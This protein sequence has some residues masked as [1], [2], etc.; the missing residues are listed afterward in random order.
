MVLAT[1]KMMDSK[2]HEMLNNTVKE[3]KQI[4]EDL[5]EKILYLRDEVARLQLEKSEPLNTEEINV[6]IKDKKIERLEDEIKEFNNTIL[7]MKDE[8]SSH[9][10][11]YEDCLLDLNNAKQSNDHM[12][13]QI[14]GYKKEIKK[15][16]SEMESRSV[17]N[18]NASED[19]IV[20]KYK[21]YKDMCK[22][23][24]DK[25]SKLNIKCTELESEIVRLN[26][27]SECNNIDDLD[28]DSD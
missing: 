23:Q 26:S 24:K 28:S 8:I 20:A 9:K 21:K 22:K 11:A 16:N 18:S 15:L 19:D 1:V 2:I 3:Q 6:R 4:I 25:I 10:Y 14:I 7:K 27:L 5:N 13:K 17:N 12:Y